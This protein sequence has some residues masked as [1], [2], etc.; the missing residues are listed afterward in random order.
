MTTSYRA[1]E[2][3]GATSGGNLRPPSRATQLAD[4][5]LADYPWT[6]RDLQS[7]VLRLGLG[8]ALIIA[9]WVG[10]SATAVW[11]EQMIWIG[12]GLAGLVVTFFAATGWLLNGLRSISRERAFVRLGLYEKVRLIESRTPA[13]APA[14]AAD[15]RRTALIHDVL[16]AAPGMRHYHRPDCQAVLGKAVDELSFAECMRLDLVPCGMCTP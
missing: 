4:E 10:A 5:Y 8:L 6:S 15:D 13:A 7:V 12:V 16:V 1:T 14:V 2:W 3:A 9:G 11:H